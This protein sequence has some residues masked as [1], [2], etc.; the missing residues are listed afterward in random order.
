[1]LLPVDSLAHEFPPPGEEAAEFIVFRIFAALEMELELLEIVV[2]EF[3][4]PLL[5]ELVV[6]ALGDW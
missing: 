3:G 2:R 1:V 5:L 4:D 6:P